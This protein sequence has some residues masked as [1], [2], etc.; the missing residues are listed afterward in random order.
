MGNSWPYPNE[1]VLGPVNYLNYLNKK[2]YI[3]NKESYE[4]FL[5]PSDQVAGRL[6]SEE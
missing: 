6:R 5:K 4:Y 2:C 1:Q 3:I